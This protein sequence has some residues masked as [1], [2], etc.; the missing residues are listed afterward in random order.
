MNPRGAIALSINMIVMIII[1][2]AI[3]AGGIV[4]LN[5]LIGDAGGLID[6]L[7]QETKQRLNELLTEQGK[8]VALPF[9]TADL[10]RGDHHIFGIGIL[11]TGQVGNTFRLTIEFDKLNDASGNSVNLDLNPEDWARFD[12]EDLTIK[13]GENELKS[14][15][16]EVPKSAPSGKYFYKA[17]IVL[18]N[19]ETYGNVQ[20]FFVTVK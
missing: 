14:I 4:L 7:N 10:D 8:Q 9:H 2:L 12:R 3:L 11:N 18:P 16:I 20:R 17:R 15:L 1:S 13:S 5:N 6:E 19:G